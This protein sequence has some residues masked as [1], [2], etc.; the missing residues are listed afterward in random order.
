MDPVRPC[1]PLVAHAELRGTPTGDCA[2]RAA[3]D[4]DPG[5]TRIAGSQRAGERDHP[6][7][8]VASTPLSCPLPRSRRTCSSCSPAAAH[9]RLSRSS[10]PVPAATT[11]AP[12]TGHG[13]RHGHASVVRGEKLEYQEEL[14]MPSRALFVL[15]EFVNFVGKRHCNIFVFI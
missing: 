8:A 12:P 7:P 10:Q 1:Q 6:P 5:R 9:V 13:A 15:V 2:G 4:T 3:T 14:W 11:T